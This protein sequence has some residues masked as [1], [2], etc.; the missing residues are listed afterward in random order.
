MSAHTSGNAFIVDAATLVFS[1]SE[2][3][4]LTGGVGAGHLERVGKPFPVELSTCIAGHDATSVCDVFR[5][6]RKHAGWRGIL[7]V[8]AA[9][10][11]GPT[12]AAGG[13]AWHPVKWCMRRFTRFSLR[14]LLILIGVIAVLLAV[15]VNRAQRQRETVEWIKENRGSVVY[16]WEFIEGPSGTKYKK[17]AKPPA[18]EWLRSLVGDEY[19]QGVVFVVFSDYESPIVLNDLTPLANLTNLEELYLPST[20][21]TDLTPLANLT[22]LEILNLSH[23]PITDLSPL[24]NLTNLETL[25]LINIQ[26]TD[27]T[28]L[29]NLTNLEWLSLDGTPITDAQILQL[30]QALPNCEIDN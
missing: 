29:A 15:Q 25:S 18:A 30:Q 4:L 26:A 22:N 21:V 16:D 28:P 5:F 13:H 24:A 7:A 12:E 11:A 17:N 19:F 20:Q 10:L 14:T 2:Q 23:N 1:T 27:P 8:V 3:S 6:Q 9:V